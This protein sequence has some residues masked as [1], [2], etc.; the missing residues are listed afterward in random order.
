[1]ELLPGLSKEQENFANAYYPIFDDVK[2]VVLGVAGIVL[3]LEDNH[4]I[5]PDFKKNIEKFREDFLQV[6]VNWSHFE[7][8]AELQQDYNKI[9]RE[10]SEIS[11]AIDTANQS[12]AKFSQQEVSFLASTLLDAYQQL[13]EVALNY[14][15]LE[16]V[17]ESKLHAH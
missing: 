5:K 17:A 14:W 15:R 8:W 9:A 13:R 6:E 4:R 7:P 12:V 3:L 11:A 1:M 16:L 10:L 2:S